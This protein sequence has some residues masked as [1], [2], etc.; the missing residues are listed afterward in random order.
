MFSETGT[1][2]RIGDG[3]SQ[4]NTNAMDS[5]INSSLDCIVIGL[6]QKYLSV[7][8]PVLNHFYTFINF[9]LV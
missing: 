9:L 3:E 8:S 2:D 7:L 5:I 6:F 4:D 1:F